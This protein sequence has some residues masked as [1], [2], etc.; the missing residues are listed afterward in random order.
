MDSKDIVRTMDL[1]GQ[2]HAVAISLDK[3]YIVI[4]IK[5]EHDKDFNDGLIPQLPAGFLIVI[6]S[7]SEDPMDW[8]METFNMVGLN[9]RS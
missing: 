1:G 6:D 3:N 4:A 7:S 2:P 9:H 5:N 8:T